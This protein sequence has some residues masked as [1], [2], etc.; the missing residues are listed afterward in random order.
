MAAV[1]ARKKI[2]I[3]QPVEH[4]CEDID[5]MEVLDVST[6]QGPSTTR[7]HPFML[8]AQSPAGFAQA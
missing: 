8:N 2:G 3:A 1:D 5:I 4:I 6:Q 7:N